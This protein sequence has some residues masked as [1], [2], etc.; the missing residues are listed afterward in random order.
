[1]MSPRDRL[2]RH[3]NDLPAK[4]LPE[5]FGD[6]QTVTAPTAIL[7]A[8]EALRLPSAPGVA[9]RSIRAAH[10]VEMAPETA[11]RGGNMGDE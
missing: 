6:L 3:W 8:V 7:P 5:R 10:G 9:V 4:A 11:V 2:W 1:M